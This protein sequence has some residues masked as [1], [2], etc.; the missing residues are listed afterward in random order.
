M[1]KIISLSVLLMMCMSMMAQLSEREKTDL[2]SSVKNNYSLTQI[3]GASLYK[4]KSGFQVLVAIASVSSAKSIEDQN[5][6]AQAKATRL[7]SEYLS[8]ATN[9][10]V[11][12]FNS[13]SSS[14]SSKESLSEK[15]IQSSMAQVKAM[16]PLF[17][18]DGSDGQTVFA[19]F[20]V[21]S[22]T[23]ARNGVAG[24][25]SIVPGVGQF[26]KGSVAKG[27]MFLGLSV[28]AATGIIV[29]ESS[30]S[31]YVNKAIEQPKYKKDYST[32]A[33]NWETARNICIGVGGAIWVW[34]IIDAFT[35]K[36]AKRK[37]V[38]SQNSSLSF[39][40]FATPNVFGQGMDIGV[41]LSFNF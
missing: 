35:T 4:T 36:S 28:A 25:L 21:I 8:G 13:E 19:Y 9:S 18:M 37:V 38:T 12:V 26:Y 7:A 39:Q 14:N 10:S 40:P 41:G 16:Q 32:K 6:E 22:K 17:K 20:L 1:R 2:I 34:N 15:I 23:A 5:R 31:S 3:D 27:T 30:R 33:D 29:C 24:V 11:T